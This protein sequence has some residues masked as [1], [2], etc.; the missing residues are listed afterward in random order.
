MRFLLALLLLPLAASA[1]PIPADDVQA[2][3]KVVE[4]QLDAFRKDDAE[5]AFSYAAPGIRK[6]FGSAEHFMAMVRSQYAVVY[7]PH[8][9]TFRTP[10]RVGGDLVQPVRMTDQE[11]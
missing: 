9:V 7:R 2:V 8:A 11:G 3:R 1:Q 4:A 5:R 6:A 10:R